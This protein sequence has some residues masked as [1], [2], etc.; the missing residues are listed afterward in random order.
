VPA[1]LITFIRLLS[2]ALWILILARVILSWTN[3]HGGGTFTAYVYQLTEPI[4]APIRRLIPP[5]SGIDW[6]PMIAILL[7]GVITRVLFSL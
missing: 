2:T 3:P 1:V 5:T 7:L 6:A 4:L